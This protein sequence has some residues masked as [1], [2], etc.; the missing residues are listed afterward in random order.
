MSGMSIAA[1]AGLLGE[2]DSLAYP[3]RMAL[4]AARAGAWAEMGRLD[5]VLADLY[6][7][8]L[9]Q[10]QIAVFM[11][12]VTG[13]EVTIRAALMDPDWCVQRSAVSAWLRSGMASAAELAGFMTDAAA[14]TRR[15]VY[16]LLRRYPSMNLADG[17]IDTV[18]DRFG[19]TEAARLLPVCAPETVI[20]LL[21]QLG[22]AVGDWSLLGVRH[23][24][25]VLDDAARQLADLT[26]PGR[27]IWWGLFGAG[28]WAAI[29]AVPG[30]VLDLLERYAP[31]TRLPGPLPDYGRLA[32]ADA[33]R[34]LALLTAPARAGWLAQARLPRSLLRHLVA[35]GVEEVGLLARRLRD[36]EPALVALL[37]AV[38]PAR[39]SEVYDEAYAG[40]DRSLA[41]PSDVMLAVLPR[42]RRTVEVRRVLELSAVRDD[43][44]L[45]LHYSAF[46]PWEQAQAALA[47]A[48]RRALAEE[49][50]AGYELMLACA[51]RSGDPS[52]LTEVVN[53]LLR[54]RNEQDPVRGRAL[55]A[56]AQVSPHLLQPAAAEALH[57]IATDALQARDAGAHTRQA[58]S[59]LAVAVLRHHFDS[60]PLLEWA[61]TTLRQLFGDRVPALGRMDTQLRRGQ[62]TEVFAAVRGWLHNGAARGEYDAL[63][64][65][66]RALHR[67]AWQ[68]PQLQDMLGRAVDAG[69][70]SSVVRQAIALWLADPTT[71]STRVEQVLLTDAST[72]TLGEV[73]NVLSAR[74]TDL[75]DLVL[76]GPPPQGKFLAKGVEWVPLWARH[77]RRW[78]PRQRRDYVTRLARLAADAGT[79][80]ST[81]T[82]AIASAA[83]IPEFGAS[84]VDRYVDSANVNLAEA[85]L[86]ALAW[87]DQPEAALPTLLTHIGDDR[88]RVA[89]YAAGRAARYLPPGRLSVILTG[90][91]LESAKVTSRKEILRLASRMS[92][93][94]AGRLLRD[95]WQQEGQHRDVRAAIVSAA[96]Q[97]LHDPDS[98]AILS[99]A[100]AGPPLDARAVLAFASPFTVA[101]EHRPRYG[102]LIAST[103]SSNDQRV[104]DTAWLTLPRWAQWIPDA[105]APIGQRLTD[106]DDRRLWRRIV[107]AVVAVL[108]A[109]LAEA[110]WLEVLDQLA[111]LDADGVGD[112][113]ERDRP[114]RQR[115]SVVAEKVAAW[116]RDADT[117]IDRTVVLEAGRRLS[118]WPDFIPQAATL[119]LSTIRVEGRD[120]QQLAAALLDICQQIED[121]PVTAAYLAD[122]LARQFY[123]DRRANLQT[124]LAA[125]DLLG[126]KTGLAPGMF[127]V[128]L[129]K[130]GARLGW[131]TQWRDQVRHLRRH[132]HPDVRSAALAIAFVTE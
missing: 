10:R 95:A 46:L 2:A 100:A 111:R 69:N 123:G 51:A 53:V 64:A 78:L 31:P 32:R 65:I 7:G 58:L 38:P 8:D 76:T 131:P 40:T 79:A 110:S 122:V 92:V 56:L 116:S 99:E 54:L 109:G 20:R 86:G 3:D 126:R 45:T 112:D 104:A 94:D 107:P 72:V 26:G 106:L 84:I 118:Q 67:R 14:D 47:G 34:V 21:P 108:N 44:V 73:W 87:T 101:E 90:G 19:D 13:H 103:L 16:R 4:F 41:R 81:R 132:Q 37:N 17:L 80:I 74:R 121:R 96:R 102:R 30:R 97:R 60:P 91:P 125:A 23:P 117:D 28:V 12:V 24:D 6:S 5:D 43:E 82:S 1:V 128:A 105:K 55:A 48:T 66:T 75:L 52:T 9:Y 70:V 39:R 63:F 49:R 129:L 113:R 18:R 77:V 83:R 62:E 25:A 50:A 114:A 35:L 124:A 98:W 85:A 27:A 71:R 15:H 59:T 130:S 89:I 68:L 88:A 119:L 36:R 115:L 61:L 120:E 11:A 29:P 33:R 57:T 22:H 42:E 127:A 93:P